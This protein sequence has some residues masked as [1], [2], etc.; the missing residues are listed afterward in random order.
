MHAGCSSW[1]F[2]PTLCRSHQPG[3]CAASECSLLC[4]DFTRL[5][6][7]RFVLDPGVRLVSIWQH[8]TMNCS[9][10]AAVEFL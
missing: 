9:D 3:E 2:C 7:H 4:D 6:L 8:Y 1:A 10:M 5:G